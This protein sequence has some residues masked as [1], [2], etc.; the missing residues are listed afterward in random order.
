MRACVYVRHKCIH[1]CIGCTTCVHT[2]TRINMTYV[3]ATHHIVTIHAHRNAYSHYMN[4][5]LRA[6]MRSHTRAHITS[7]H[8]CMH[9][10]LYYISSQ[11]HATTSHY[12]HTWHKPTSQTYIRTRMHTSLQCTHACVNACMVAR[13]HTYMHRPHTYTCASASCTRSCAPLMQTW[14][15]TRITTHRVTP[16]NLHVKHARTNAY[17]FARIL[18]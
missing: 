12:K 7:T 9:A 13:M 2:R 3:H 11:R 15:H 14:T 6:N 5:R 18:A 17:T 4:T 16:H 10:R 1:E 8:A